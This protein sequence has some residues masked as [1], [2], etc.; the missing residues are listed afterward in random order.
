MTNSKYV[1]LSALAVFTLS[2]CSLLGSKGIVTKGDSQ[3]SV[4]TEIASS[5]GTDKDK[6]GNAKTE[7]DKQSPK[8]SAPSAIAGKL[9][10]EWV[11]VG[12]GTHTVS[13]DEDMPYVN[14]DETD[15]KFYASNGCNV[16]NGSFALSG[17]GISFSHVLSTMME[18]PDV[19]YQ[20]SIT[21]SLN[22]GVSH[23][24]KIEQKGQETY[25][26]FTN[27]SKQK[28]LTLRRHNA[29]A[30]NGN[31]QVTSIDGEKIDND[32]VNLFIDVPELKVHGNTG[33]NYFNGGISLDPLLPN[34]I[35]FSHMGVTMR[36]CPNS[37]VERAYLVALEETVTY[38]LDGSTLH[39][40]NNKGKTIITF[41]KL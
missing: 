22:E 38:N 26:Y 19:P 35:A 1:L 16:L 28:I 3:E 13:R 12:V 36:L 33:C 15:G 24:V 6:K 8:Q 27:N 11:I 30:L 31:W 34:S 17:D 23:H 10:G 18:C 20:K 21:N 37:E 25:L 5:S 39:F 29:E 40:L 7:P 4:K 14:F 41:K 9:Q 32:E 2:S